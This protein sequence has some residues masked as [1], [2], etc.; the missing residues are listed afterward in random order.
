MIQKHVVLAV[1]TFERCIFVVNVMLQPE[2]TCITGSE[3]QAG[4][5]DTWAFDLQFYVEVCRA[6]S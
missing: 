2:N 1:G 6:R 4:V 3:V 5:Q